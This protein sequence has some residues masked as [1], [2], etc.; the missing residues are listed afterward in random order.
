MEFE[1]V[2]NAVS[3]GSDVSISVFW[4]NVRPQATV[5]LPL[6]VELRTVNAIVKMKLHEPHLRTRNTT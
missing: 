3:Y 1:T 4:C 5:S 6:F 2:H